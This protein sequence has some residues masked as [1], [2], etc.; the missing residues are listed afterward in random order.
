[1]SILSGGVLS[2]RTAGDVDAVLEA[3][4]GGDLALAALVAA[5]HD[6]DLVLRTVSTPRQTGIRESDLHPCGWECCALRAFRGA[7][8]SMAPE[9]VRTLHASCSSSSYAHDDPTHT[10]RRTEVRLSRFAARAR[11]IGLC[12]GHCCWIRGCR[13]SGEKEGRV[14]MR[15]IEVRWARS[16]V[17]RR[18]EKQFRRGG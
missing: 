2:V 12:L 11:E 17:C 4:D 6:H 16:L 18:G 13:V 7:P 9:D 8:Y 14:V 5:A 10:T 3:V 1:V 15:K